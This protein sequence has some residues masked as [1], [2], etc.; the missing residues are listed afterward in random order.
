MIGE[1]AA[2]TRE[3]VDLRASETRAHFDVVAE[4][5]ESRIQNIAEGHGTLNAGF[6]D[7]RAGQERIEERMTGLEL[8]MLA[9]E[10]YRAG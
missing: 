5:L 9:L 8:R 3:Y 10:R 4:R 2:E 6:A 1:E 7:L